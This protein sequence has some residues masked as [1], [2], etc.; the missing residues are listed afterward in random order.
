MT[1]EYT[2]VYDKAAYAAFCEE[3]K[4]CADGQRGWVGLTKHAK[5]TGVPRNQLIVVAKAMGLAVDSHGGRHGY[6]A[7]K[8][9]H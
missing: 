5:L 1:R 8:K 3:I 9:G 7:H 6:T 4:Q 2:G